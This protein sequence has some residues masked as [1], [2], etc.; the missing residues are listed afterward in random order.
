[1]QFNELGLDSRLISALT[2]R[3]LI[4]ATDVQEQAIP[5]ALLGQDVLASSKTGSGKTLA[6]LLPA[7]QR[8]LKKKALSTRDARVVILAP[9]RELASQVFGELKLL[10]P[11]KP[12]SVALI[13]GGENFNDQAKVLRKDPDFVVATP[14]RLADHLEKRHLYLNG[15]EMLILDEAD[16]M[17]DLG[18]GDALRA[19]DNAADHRQRQT[20]MFSATLD[21]PQVVAMAHKMLNNPK[22]IAIGQAH[23]KHDDID[24][25][26]HLAN[27]LA[28]KE[29]MLLALLSQHADKQTIVFTATRSDTERLSELLAAQQLNAIALSGELNQAKRSQMIEAFSQQKADI[30]VT[31]D[32]ASRGLDILSVGL[33]I[34][35][36][37]PK[38][39]EEYVH[40]IGRTGRAGV[41]GFAVS[42]IGPKDWFN[43]KGVE[44]FLQCAVKPT[45]LEGFSVSFTGLRPKKTVTKKRTQRRVEKPQGQTKKQP[46][47]RFR[48]GSFVSG[49]QVGDKP[50]LKKKVPPTQE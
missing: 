43:F 29:K 48:K 2:H 36:D 18:F 12:G 17:L 31:T 16:R 4:E 10:V 1:M 33:V 32:V 41:Q 20:M 50:M 15:L 49:Q 35:F 28:Q 5:L 23:Q 46:E 21:E 47:K 13:V 6:F 24:Q 42:L 9:T 30:L 11:R 25:Q 37:M 38:H 8:V 3:N 26:F 14:G 45:P 44:R 22:R 27:D 7:V 39:S 19:I 34:N 40:R